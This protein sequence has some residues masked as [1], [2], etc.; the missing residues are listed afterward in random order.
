MVDVDATQRRLTI[1]GTDAAGRRHDLSLQLTTDY[2]DTA[3]VCSV[4]LH[5]HF[6]PRPALA[7]DRMALDRGFGGMGG[8]GGAGSGAGKGAGGGGGGGDGSRS[9]SALGVGGGGGGVCWQLSNVVSQWEANLAMYQELWRHLDDLDDHVRILEPEP[10]RATGRPPRSALHRRVAI[11][12]HASVLVQLDPRA[13]S[14]VPSVRFLGK[15][16]L[17]TPLR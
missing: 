4:D 14:A 3:P 2:P 9:S 15:D 8:G 17:V 1:I 7:D 11:A 16:S 5:A 10:S 12:P 6:T 13:P